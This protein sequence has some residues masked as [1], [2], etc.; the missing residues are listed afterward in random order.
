MANSLYK[1]NLR[2]IIKVVVPIKINIQS[3]VINTSTVIPCRHNTGGIGQ[4]I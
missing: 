1:M 3:K 4:L 2:G